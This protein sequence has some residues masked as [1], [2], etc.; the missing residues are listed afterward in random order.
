MT[1][2]ETSGKKGGLVGDTSSAGPRPL[3]PEQIK[4]RKKDSSRKWGEIAL[5]V[6]PALVLF[7]VGR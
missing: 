3:S 1:T 4:Q 7:F 6:G 5:F 2:M